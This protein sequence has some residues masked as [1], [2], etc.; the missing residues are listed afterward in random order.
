MTAFAQESAGYD[1][2]WSI[3]AAVVGIALLV[4]AWWRH[5]RDK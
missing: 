5:R 3:I 2:F 4:H 1:W